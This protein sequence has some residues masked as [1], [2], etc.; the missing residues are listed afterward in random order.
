[1]GTRLAHDDVVVTV[2]FP[3]AWVA[4]PNVTLMVEPT[5][6]VEGKISLLLASVRLAITAER[7]LCSSTLELAEF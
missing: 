4:V 1:M 2:A 7:F 5:L 3:V 6:T